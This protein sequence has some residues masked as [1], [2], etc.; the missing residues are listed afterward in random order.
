M[1]YGNRVPSY[2]KMTVA[3]LKEIY[4][5]ELSHRLQEKIKQIPRIVDEA[6][7]SVVC[8]VVGRTLGIER[9]AWGKWATRYR[10]GDHDL[11]FVHQIEESA[12]S[13]VEENADKLTKTYLS[14]ISREDTEEL[15]EAYREEVRNAAY[16]L[17]AEKAR[18]EARKIFAKFDGKKKASDEEDSDD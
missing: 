7:Q 17:M 11:T 13:Y 4:A 10:T 3:Q 12:Q 8:E 9:D 5:A 14:K 1:S 2:G 6:V 18:D 16:S 15:K